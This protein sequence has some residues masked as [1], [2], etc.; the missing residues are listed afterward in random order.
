MLVIGFNIHL[1]SLIGFNIHS[2]SDH[3]R[4]VCP[5]TPNFSTPNTR[6]K[7]TEKLEMKFKDFDQDILLFNEWKISNRVFILNCKVKPVILQSWSYCNI[8]T[9]FNAFK[10]I[11]LKLFIFLVLK[12]LP[13]NSQG[14]YLSPLYFGF[15]FRFS[16]TA[17]VIVLTIKA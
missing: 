12:I 9:K 1:G 13:N 7:K 11:H 16:S 2:G 14:R 4:I 8:Q 15:Y 17:R 6:I 5:K 10:H 3:M